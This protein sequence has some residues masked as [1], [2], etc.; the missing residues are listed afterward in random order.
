MEIYPEPH[1][2]YGENI[3]MNYVSGRYPELPVW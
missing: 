1:S 3:N 2:F